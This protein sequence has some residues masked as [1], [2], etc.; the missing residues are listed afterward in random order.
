MKIKNFFKYITLGIVG[1]VAVS[2]IL[3]LMLFLMLSAICLLGKGI[4]LVGLN[5][6]DADKVIRMLCEN[7]SVLSQDCLDYGSLYLPFLILSLI[8]II[9][10]AFFLVGLGKFVE[11]FW[12]TMKKS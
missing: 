5:I 9:V 2:L 7:G 10:V 3:I 6:S 11:E 4:A 1:I 8:L 12:I